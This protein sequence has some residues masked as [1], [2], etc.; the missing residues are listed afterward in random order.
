MKKREERRKRRERDMD[1][2]EYYEDVV[3]RRGA[4]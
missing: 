4:N 1:L 2:I 3:H